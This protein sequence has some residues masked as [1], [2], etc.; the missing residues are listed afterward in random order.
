MANYYKDG[1]II[2]SD[3]NGIDKYLNIII[4]HLSNSKIGYIDIMGTR[5]K[6][7]NMIDMLYLCKDS[8]TLWE[9]KN[10][11]PSIICFGITKNNFPIAVYEVEPLDLIDTKTIFSFKFKFSY[12]KNVLYVSFT[13]K[14]SLGPY[15]AVA[16]LTINLIDHTVFQYGLV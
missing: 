9:C 5:I 3:S 13:F 1:Y 14:S 10:F 4:T 11:P 16:F 15:S 7:E 12:I 2:F 8:N 6:I